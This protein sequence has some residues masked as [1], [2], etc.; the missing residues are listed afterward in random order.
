MVKTVSSGRTEKTLR[1]LSY[2]GVFPKC[3]ETSSAT[4]WPRGEMHAV[5]FMKCAAS[6]SQIALR[7]SGMTDVT[8]NLNSKPEILRPFRSQNDGME[9][10]IPACKRRI[11][12]KLPSVAVEKIIEG[13]RSLS[14]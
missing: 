10:H 7:A 13:Q 6:G 4:S 2:L 12:R 11:F 5:H 14:P 3:M 9:V 8:F 1:A